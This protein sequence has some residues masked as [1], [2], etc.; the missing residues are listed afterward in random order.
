MDINDLTIEVRDITL[1][2]V[3]VITSKWI[4]FKAKIM[5]NGVGD[6]ELTLPATH[7]MAEALRQP[8]SGIIVSLKGV[9]KFS[10][11]TTEPIR[12]TD[13]TNPDGTYTFRGLTDDVLLADALAF[14]EPS[15]PDPTSQATANDLR[16]GD[17]ETVMREFVSANV[18]PTAPAGRM[19]GFRNY[20]ELEPTNQNRG[21]N[22]VKTARFD[23]LGVLLGEIATVAHLG[24]QIVQRGTALRFE[25]L[26]VTDR[27]DTVRLDIQNGTLTKETLAVSPP[28]V[29]QVVVA[30][31][32]EGVFRTFVNRTSTESVASETVWGRRI[33]VFKDQRNTDELVELEQAGDKLL[34]ES[35]FTA[36]AVKAI[37]ADDQ[38]MRYGIDWEVGDTVGLV[39]FG[40]ETT[41]T[42]TAAVIVANSGVVAVGASIGDVTGFD[43]TTAESKRV[44][45]TARRV[46]ALEK[47]GLALRWNA[48]RE[49]YE[50]NMDGDVIQH[51][52]EDLVIRVK[53]N[54]GSV[55][56]P[57]FTPVMFA[58]S[59]GDTIKVAPAVADGTVDRNYFAGITAEEIPADGFGFVQ[60]F[61]FVE[62]INTAVW[63]AGTILYVD[64]LNPG[65]LTSTLPEQPAWTFPVAAITRSHAQTGRALV[66]AIPAGGD[67]IPQIISDVSAPVDAELD[68]LWYDSTD[69]SMY[70]KY[71]DGNT[72]QW[73]EVMTSTNGY[74][75][76]LTQ[77]ES[78]A[79]QPISIARMP[80]GSV[81]G[82]AQK[83]SDSRVSYGLSNTATVITDLTLSYTPKVANSLIVVQWMI[84]CETDANIVMLAYRNNAIVTTSGYQSYN[85]GVGNVYYSGMLAGAYDQN[86]DSTPSN[87]F[88]Q[89][90]APANST[91]STTFQVAARTS[92]NAFTTNFHLN[93]TFSS[94]GGDYH[95]MMVSTVT[96]WEI[97]Q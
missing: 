47:S 1:T 5:H 7:P 74:D 37:P 8:G 41:A 28:S 94:L 24:F 6:W 45:D 66:R 97:A 62:H 18:G 65:G 80:S 34:E 23:N 92:V 20:I 91:S 9:E 89:Y 82:F 15:N 60:W 27:S 71:D 70:I 51:I 63:P 69:G 49:T 53:N 75:D 30:G 32:G 87:Y 61:G 19:V 43:A 59:T 2:R 56:I 83:R 22:I 25:V 68:N 38:T 58:G 77:L 26:N 54:S 95:E 3:G 79:A 78:I 96:L 31:Q 67:S 42:V 44:E 81:I 35:G 88:L 76:R 14:P 85:T 11:P 4:D 90:I 16:S 55:A 10:G 46:D 73:V 13:R 72:V 57:K 40:Q 39:T 12:E 93:R 21:I 64:P 50:F 17:A 86:N 29:T 52:G 84:N 48:E 36:T 33:E